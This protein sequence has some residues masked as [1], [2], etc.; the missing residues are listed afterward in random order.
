MIMLKSLNFDLRRFLCSN[1]NR[2]V[3]E[4]VHTGPDHILLVLFLGKS[5]FKAWSSV[6][7]LLI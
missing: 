4:S 2:N 6:R 5:G 1:S 3:S 7:A